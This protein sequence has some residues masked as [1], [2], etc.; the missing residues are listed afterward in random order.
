[1]GC[2]TDWA[3]SVTK[4][5]CG[6]S[7]PGHC[8]GLRRTGSRMR[9][10]PALVAVASRIARCVALYRDCAAELR[11]GCARRPP[12]IGRPPVPSSRRRRRAPRPQKTKCRPADLE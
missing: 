7:P 4:R 12:A 9:S 2:T 10:T 8:T 5:Y 6:P 1:M 11:I 3:V